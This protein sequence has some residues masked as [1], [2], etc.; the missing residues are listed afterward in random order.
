[1]KFKVPGLLGGHV[2]ST[3]EEAHNNCPSG[4]GG[5]ILVEMSSIEYIRLMGEIK[6][7]TE[8]IRQLRNMIDKIEFQNHEKNTELQKNI[9]RNTSLLADLNLS[10]QNN[11][12]VQ[13]ELEKL[14][15]A[16]NAEQQKVASLENGV[17]TLKKF[18]PISKSGPE[19]VNQ[20]PYAFGLSFKIKPG[21]KKHIDHT[22]RSL[23]LL[24]HM[25]SCPVMTRLSVARLFN[26]PRTSA[27]KVLEKLWTGGYLDLI[28]CVGPSDRF[29]VYYLP[30]L[31]VPKSA[32]QV[33]QMAI[34]SLLYVS[35]VLSNGFIN[36]NFKIEFKRVMRDLSVMGDRYKIDDYKNG[37]IKGFYLAYIS[38]IYTGN[39]K[40][41]H[42][43]LVAAPVRETD[44]KPS[45]RL[46]NGEK[47]FYIFPVATDDEAMSRVREGNAYMSDYRLITNNISI[48]YK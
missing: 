22:D 23:M 47:L 48:G 18:V 37:D 27:T 19:K 26:C 11:E 40:E 14:Q 15:E 8:E 17:N 41:V 20:N 44:E 24:N 38:Y 10:K 36:M 43:K 9:N 4:R 7:Q 6:S 16:F 3:L 39:E 1:M 30:T 42:R 34:L 33:C 21:L 2:Y 45:F 5:A 35:L 12:K 32:N 46:Q 25:K 31:R 28:T 29:D 13:K